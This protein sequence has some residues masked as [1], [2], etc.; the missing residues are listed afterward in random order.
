MDDVRMIKL[1]EICAL[2]IVPPSALV[3]LIANRALL[4]A[5]EDLRKLDNRTAVACDFGT[6]YWQFLA[7][8]LACPSLP[9]QAEVRR[10]HCTGIREKLTL[11]M[12]QDVFTVGQSSLAQTAT[13]LAMIEAFD[14][15]G[16]YF[17]LAS[18]THDSKSELGA[19]KASPWACHLYNCSRGGGPRFQQRCSHLV[20]GEFAWLSLL[21]RCIAY[22]SAGHKGCF[23]QRAALS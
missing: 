13:S 9:C 16:M 10:E 17:W 5:K 3:V 2:N 11:R 12:Q 7:R 21:W 8:E 15:N 23:L 14:N 1:L 20:N 6:G 18:F 22:L 4:V 19:L